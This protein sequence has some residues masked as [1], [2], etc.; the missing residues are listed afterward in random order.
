MQLAQHL[1]HLKVNV[2]E[3][4]RIA[5][6]TTSIPILDAYPSPINACAAT[7]SNVQVAAWPIAF[8]DCD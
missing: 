7:R 4:E 5:P 1:V 6:M 2:Q 3:L 8:A